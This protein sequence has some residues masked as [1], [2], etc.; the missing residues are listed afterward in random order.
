MRELVIANFPEQVGI[1]EKTDVYLKQVDDK[2]VNDAYHSLSIEGYSVTTE[3]I[4]KVRKGDWN[5]DENAEDIKQVDAMAARGYWQ[6]FQAVK[7][8][9]REILEGKDAGTITENDHGKWY[10]ELF[11]PSVI[12]GIIKPSDLAGYRNNPV[13]IGGSKHTPP[14]AE[15]IR[16]E[17]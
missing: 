6:A 16:D 7:V 3:L 12:A 9:I 13:F 11:S 14:G 15:A 5:P 1:P 2:Y 10:R 8:S 17:I 4:D